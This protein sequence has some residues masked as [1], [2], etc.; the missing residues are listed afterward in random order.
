MCID[1]RRGADGQKFSFSASLTSPF[2]VFM[3][4]NTFA[5]FTFTLNT[6]PYAPAPTFL[7]ISMSFSSNRYSGTRTGDK[8]KA[9]DK[10]VAKR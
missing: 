4:K 3:A 6:S 8:S 9:N 10:C 2:N 7:I 5:D 1:V